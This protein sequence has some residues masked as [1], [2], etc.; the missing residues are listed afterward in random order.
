MKN[1]PKSKTGHRNN[2]NPGPIPKAIFQFPV[3][4]L[5]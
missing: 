4:W 1:K 5:I 2:L 3:V